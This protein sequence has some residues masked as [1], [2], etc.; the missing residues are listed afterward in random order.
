MPQLFGAGSER[1]LPRWLGSQPGCGSIRYEMG[2]PG[3]VEYA[4]ALTNTKGK[5][6]NVALE[7]DCSRSI[8]GISVASLRPTE[9]KP[10][11]NPDDYE[12]PYLQD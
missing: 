7:E 3:T 1:P 4:S 12:N 9:L 10:H 2:I 8:A 5:L 6:S 11:K